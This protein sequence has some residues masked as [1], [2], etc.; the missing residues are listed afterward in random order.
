MPF[1]KNEETI[2]LALQELKTDMK[3]VKRA[4]GFL[5]TLFIAMLTIMLTRG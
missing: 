1:M 3:W 5:S 2:M 4:L